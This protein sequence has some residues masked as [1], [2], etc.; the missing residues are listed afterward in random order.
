MDKYALGV[1]SPYIP[2]TLSMKNRK[3]DNEVKTIE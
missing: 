2:V 1:L 3:F